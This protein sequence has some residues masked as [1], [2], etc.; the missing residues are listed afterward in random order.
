V[1]LVPGCRVELHFNNEKLIVARDCWQQEHR[2]L[3]KS[4]V[5]A[6]VISVE[7]FNKQDPMFST[8]CNLFA[9]V[10]GFFRLESTRFRV[11]WS[12]SK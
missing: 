5:Q 9:P 7:V 4:G 2:R 6:I 1:K 10:E 8:W 3:V 11:I 12:P